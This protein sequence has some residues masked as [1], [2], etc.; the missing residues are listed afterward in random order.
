MAASTS[1]RLVDLLGNILKLLQ[2]KKRSARDLCDVLQVVKEHEDFAWRLLGRARST[3]VMVGGIPADQLLTKLVHSNCDVHPWA[4][5]LM[6]RPEF[7]T[8]TT[9]KKVP[10][11]RK[12]VK[13]L[14][15]TSSPTT[16][17]VFECINGLGKLCQ[18]ED[19][20]W[21]VMGDQPCGDI[22]WVAMKP[23]IG[24]G[25]IPEIFQNKRL[26]DGSWCL[27]TSDAR[28]DRQWE[29]DDSFVFRSRE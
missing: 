10:F 21:L 9:P 12:T 24:S 23:I 29:L 15:F 5:D 18:P 26:S 1:D 7:V 17:Q 16:T 8:S 11:M 4:R 27:N 6:S 3:W 2:E 14:G 19:G 13:E 20:A 28:P 22:L 25:G